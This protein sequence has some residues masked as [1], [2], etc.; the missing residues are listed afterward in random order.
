[1]TLY[2]RQV[3]LVLLLVNTLSS[4]LLHPGHQY[5]RQYYQLL[6]LLLLLLLLFKFKR[7]KHTKHLHDPPIYFLPN[8]EKKEREERVLMVYGPCMPTNLT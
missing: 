1:M 4:G 5:V 2:P 7:S 8:W 6:L 3:W